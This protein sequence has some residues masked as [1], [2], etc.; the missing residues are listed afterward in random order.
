[1]E[2]DLIE[3]CNV[4]LRRWLA[5]TLTTNAVAENYIVAT[6]LYLLC[7]VDST[8]PVCLLLAS[9]KPPW[10]AT[11]VLRLSQAEG[12]TNWPLTSSNYTS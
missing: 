6:L 9:H 11:G 1:M 2:R 5:A 4:A 8:E 12:T 3:V 7:Q 10:V